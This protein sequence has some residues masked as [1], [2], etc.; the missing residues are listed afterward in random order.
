MHELQ[1]PTQRRFADPA[2]VRR[3]LQEAGQDG[4]SDRLLRRMEE[5][6]DDYFNSDPL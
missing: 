1:R 6:A 2:V 3:A 4:T 5:H